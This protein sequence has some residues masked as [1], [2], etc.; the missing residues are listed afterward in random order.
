M[1]AGVWLG[2]AQALAGLPRFVEA[3]LPGMAAQAMPGAMA[4]T[5]VRLAVSGFDESGSTPQ[6][7]YPVPTN[8][9]PA[10]LSEAIRA[11][12]LPPPP[13]LRDVHEVAPPARKPMIAIVIDDLGEDIA[14]TDKAM[15]LPQQV[16][17]S[18]LPFADTTP[19]LA[20][21]GEK[22]G[23]LVMAHVPMQA[24]DGRDPGPMALKPGMS[25]DEIARRLSWN[26]A[27]VPGAVGMNNHEGSRFT[28]DAELLA[29]VMATLKARHLFFLDS[30]TSGSSVGEMTAL[31]AGVMTGGRDIFLDD[32]QSPIAVQAQ[33]AALI[34]TARRQ[35]VAIAIGHPHD[36]TLKLLAAWL[37]QDH[38]VTLVPLDDAMRARRETALAAR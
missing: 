38:G 10:W 35:G 26:L 30:R 27:R 37:V 29:P 7:L 32:D 36:M 25:A 3:A 33:L 12:R 23:H 22:R 2:G 8:P 18:F 11:S 14:G 16:A 34:A 28:A 19:F 5:Q 24:L 21:E 4:Q 1:L 15:A 6:V 13:A 17:L 9:M 20:A 31:H